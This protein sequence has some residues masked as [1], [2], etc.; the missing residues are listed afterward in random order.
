[1][2]SWQFVCCTATHFKHL[3]SIEEVLSSCA[4]AIICFNTLGRKA[5]I[6]TKSQRKNIVSCVGSVRNKK[7]NKGRL[8]EGLKSVY[9]ILNN[10]KCRNN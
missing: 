6:K 2:P 10:K 7:K 4:Q 9:P 5:R 1:M 8:G 3:Q